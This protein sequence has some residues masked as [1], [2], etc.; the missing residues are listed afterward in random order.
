M[1]CNE[2]D[3]LDDGYVYNNTNGGGL[4]PAL[5][6]PPAINSFETSGTHM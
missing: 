4:Y 3:S 5:L 1:L 6:S 2:I